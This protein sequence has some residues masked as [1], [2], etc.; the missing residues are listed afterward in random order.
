V[1]LALANDALAAS[2][3]LPRI[4]QRLT[5]LLKPAPPLA[6]ALSRPLHEVVAGFQAARVRNYAGHLAGIPSARRAGDV[7]DD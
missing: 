2:Q 7:D 5:C 1:E 3:A 4:P 6:L